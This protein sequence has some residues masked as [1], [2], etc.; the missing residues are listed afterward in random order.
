MLA[1]IGA[2]AMFMPIFLIV[3]PL[4]GPEFAIA[5]PSLIYDTYKSNFVI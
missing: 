1:G 2:A 4:L 5:G 3:F